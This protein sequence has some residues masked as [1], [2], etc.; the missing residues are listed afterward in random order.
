MQEIPN[1]QEDLSITS[2]CV[3]KPFPLGSLSFSLQANAL[4]FHS[5]VGKYAQGY[6]SKHINKLS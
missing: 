1:F 5:P 4:A 3:D 6:F 2:N